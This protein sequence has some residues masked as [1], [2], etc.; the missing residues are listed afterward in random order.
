M[1]MG[2]TVVPPRHGDNRIGAPSLSHLR[3]W[4]GAHAWVRGVQM[5]ST[6]AEVPMRR[7][8]PALALA[9]SLAA[10]PAAALQ[11]PNGMTIPTPL[12]CDGGK[13]GG[14]SAIFACACKDPG[15]C[16]IGAACPGGSTSCD[17]GTNSTCE[18][19]LWHNPNDNSCIPSNTSGLDPLA[20]ASTTP[21]TF[22]PA[23]PLTFD[24]LSRGTALFKNVF[25]WYN[26]TGQKPSFSDLH[27][28]QD[29]NAAAGQSVVLDVNNEP[30][31]KGGDVGFFLIT[32]ESSSQHG[33]CANGNCCASVARAMNGEGYVYFS[34]RKYNPD[35]VGQNS[36]I[37]LLV[38]QSHV[39][40]EKFY[41]AWEDT[42]NSSSGNFTDFVS[43]VSGIQCSGGGA[44]CD[45]GKKGVCALGV[46]MCNHGVLGCVQ[47]FQ[48]GGE[49]CNGL[50]DDCDG[51]V[52][53]GASCPADQVCHNGACVPHCGS[54]EFPCTGSTECDSATG[55]CV[56]AACKTVTCPAGQICA[57]GAC[58]TPCDG[59]VCPHGQDCVADACVDL[60]KGVVCS[61]GQ[62]CRQG[63]CFAGCNSCDGISCQQP[64]KCDTAS[65]QCADPSCPGGCPAGEVCNAGQCQDACTGVK[66]PPGQTC[67]AGSCQG[68]GMPGTGG[69]FTGF[70]GNGGSSGT[71]ASS[72]GGGSGTG[73]DGFTGNS[74]A[75]CGCAAAAPNNNLALAMVGIA[76]T[77]PL[78]RRRAR[79]GKR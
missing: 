45:T 58:R 3:T 1:G 19:T 28:M 63:K 29:C 24:L 61:T 13:P 54:A 14:L 42:F 4:S 49:Q 6:V 79:R 69:G 39:W 37:H 33:T 17:P 67:N 64:L 32:P 20:E 7:F 11:Q 62:I 21:E 55:L 41:F 43:A 60:C 52:D 22:H 47:L 66:C 59:V 23:C 53:Q 71:G 75:G 57:E 35:F 8:A 72:G 9:V 10:A 73:G 15:V 50:D 36:Y 5:R 74:G 25:G 44:P 70:G 56:D 51:A 31:Y 78:A 18:T 2:P 77:A 65:G 40:P 48:P 68:S 76:L 46:T 30:A 34:E 12:T 26:V 38:Y 27:V 16:N